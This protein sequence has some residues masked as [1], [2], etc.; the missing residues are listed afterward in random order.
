MRL[1]FIRHGQSVNNALWDES[2]SNS[3]RSEDPELTAA[4]HKQA[5]LLAHFISEKDLAG[6]QNGNRRESSRDTFG[7]THLYTSL[8]VRSVATATYVAQATGLTL[9]GWPEIHECGGIYEDGEEEGQRFGLPGK[10]RSYFTQHYRHL[11]LPESVTDDGWWNKPFETYEDRPQRAAQVYQMLLE[12]HGQTNDRVAIVSHGGFYME[13]MR[14][15]FKIGEENCWY[16]MNN[17]GIS[18]F[19]FRDNGEISLIY[20]NRTEHLPETLIT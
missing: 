5:S 15:F 3:G 16:M 2:G 19:D 12:R 7:F 14:V 6:R 18:R 13:L 17:T 8:M 10:T 20:H 1:F 11:V 4:G 9:V